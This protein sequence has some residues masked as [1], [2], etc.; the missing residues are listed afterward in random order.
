MHIVLLLPVF[1]LG[2]CN[3]CLSPLTLWV[4]IPPRWEVLDTTLRDKVCQWLATGFLRV[5]R[6]LH[7]WNWPPRYNSNIVESCVKYHKPQPYYLFKRLE[8][9]WNIMRCCRNYWNKPGFYFYQNAATINSLI[10]LPLSLLLV[11][12]V[13]W[14]LCI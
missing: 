9:F 3:Q 14:C 7:Q 1:I 12:R 5:L 6:F 13:Y 11:I 2:L 4:R 8:T 10:I